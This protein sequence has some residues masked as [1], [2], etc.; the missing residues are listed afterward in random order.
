MK[1]PA[2]VVGTAQGIEELPAPHGALPKSGVFPIRSLTPNLDSHHLDGQENNVNGAV[3]L[4]LAVLSV[5]SRRDR[6]QVV[7]PLSQ[8]K[9]TPKAHR[10]KAARQS[11]RSWDVAF[12]PFLKVSHPSAREDCTFTR[13]QRN[14]LL[15]RSARAQALGYGFLKVFSPLVFGIWRQESEPLGLV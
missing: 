12:I 15:P 14:V 8:Q 5:P 11:P 4:A 3:L 6:T 9:D 1:S 13:N 2:G 10:D 7:C